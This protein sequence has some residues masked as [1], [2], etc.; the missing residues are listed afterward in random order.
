MVYIN[1]E[2]NDQVKEDGMGRACS[3][4]GGDTEYL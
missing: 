1:V 4:N 2:L 3:M